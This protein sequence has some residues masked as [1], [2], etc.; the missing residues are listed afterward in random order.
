MVTAQQVL[1]GVADEYNSD[2]ED[3]KDMYDSIM[4]E[5]EDFDVSIII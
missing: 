2:E 3:Q 5:E 1:A 4:L